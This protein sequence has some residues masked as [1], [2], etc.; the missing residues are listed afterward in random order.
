MRNSLYIV[1][2]LLMIVL[3][4]CGKFENI[5]VKGVQEVKFKGLENSKLHLSL[6]LDIENPNK[7]SICIKSMEFKTMLGKREFGTVKIPRKIKINGHSREN[8]EIPL[9]IKLRTAADAL[10]LMTNREKLLKQMTVDGYIKGG[11][12][13]VVKKIRVKNQPIQDLMKEFSKP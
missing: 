7:T 1:G 13:P 5:Q 2:L 12:F 9:E 4:G 11:K 10:K 8:Y 6:I 3:S